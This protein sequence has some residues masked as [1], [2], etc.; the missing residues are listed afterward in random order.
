ML[1]G[2]QAAIC[3]WLYIGCNMIFSRFFSTVWPR[4]PPRAMRA[5]TSA[6]KRS[7]WCFLLF[8]RFWAL[9]VPY[10]GQKREGIP[11]L[12]LCPKKKVV[13]I[14]SLTLDDGLPIAGK[15]LTPP[16]SAIS[17]SSY[18][19]ILTRP[20]KILSVLEVYQ[21]LFPVSC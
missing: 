12:G 1:S 5:K 7:L 4:S 6:R 3:A 10:L 21:T 15:G 11:F 20:N 13:D 18:T 19:V 8:L 16:A 17:T 14:R 2:G 9:F